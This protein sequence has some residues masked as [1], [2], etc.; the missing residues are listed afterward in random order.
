MSE[1]VAGFG[2]KLD[3]VARALHAAFGAPQRRELR[4]VST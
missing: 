1:F 3:D 4:D 2:G